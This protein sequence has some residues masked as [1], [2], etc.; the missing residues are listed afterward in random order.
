MMKKHF[1]ISTLLLVISLVFKTEGQEKPKGQE[2]SKEDSVKM[3]IRSLSNINSSFD[4]FAPVI[5]AD[6]E[7]MIFTS[8]RPTEKRDITKNMAGM[9]NIYVSY[10]D[11]YTWKWGTPQLLGESV[12]QPGRNNSAIALSND[13]QRMLVYRGDPD[14][15]IYESDLIG[16][17]WSEPVKLPPPINSNKH[18]SS[19]SISP[20]GRTIYFVSNRKHGLGG[21]DI[22]Q[23]RQDIKGWG[24]AENL[25]ATINTPQNEEGV[26][27]HPD[28]KT[29][30]F[31]SKGHD[32]K[33]GYD[34]FKSV[35]ENGKWSNPV[36]LGDS[37]NTANDDLFF[38]LTASG[39][40]A[41]Y[42]SIRA[43]GIGG[44]DIYEI[45]VKNKTTGGGSKLILFKGVVV[46]FE[47][48]K[49][50]G[51]KMEIT[52]ND[53]NE[54]IATVNSNSVTGKFL[55]SLPAGKNY[56]ITIKKE[57]YL[58]H[59]ENF[60]I[61][62]TAT[63]KEVTKNITL[64]TLDIGRKIDLKNIFYDYG[65]ATL[66]PE[67]ISELNQLVK[68]LNASTSIII[69]IDSYTDSQSSAEFN[70]KLSQA[71]SQ[72]VV[73]FL[74]AAGFSRDQLVPKGFGAANPVASNATEEG[75]KQ[76]RRTEIRIL[77]K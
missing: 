51:A 52:D 69:E 17:E 54:I 14:G 57:G 45:T 33:G 8:N 66:K 61:P 3:S 75:R 32:A 70:L 10:Y 7:M 77:N 68:L 76:N 1:Y 20:D 64:A 29:L 28:G 62:S 55:V 11:D 49:P 2:K 26:F 13:G 37:V 71:R 72:S 63:Y 46:D 56:G 38:T 9:E 24:K 47:S 39:K 22:W 53:K 42:S 15:D 31:S 6:G 5:S 16:E 58:F 4:E 67:S 19:A 60:D 25:G 40:T 50:V 73:D 18:E 36:S 74:F 34:I 43:G 65:K 12:N 35:L 48:L 41:Y 27:I 44:K 59:S 21:L 30:Y 23:C